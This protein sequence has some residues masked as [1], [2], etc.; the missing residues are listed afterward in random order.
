MSLNPKY[1]PPQVTACVFK[2]L[3]PV[4]TIAACLAHKDPFLLPPDTPSRLVVW[5]P[6]LLPPDTP[7]RLV[8]F[9]L[10]PD[11]PSRLV[12]CRKSFN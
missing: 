5:D 7:S 8:P 4:V 6:F 11:T 9:L 10:A 12:V 1:C 3:D 2:C